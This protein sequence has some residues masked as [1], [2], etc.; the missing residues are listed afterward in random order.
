MIHN[1]PFFKINIFLIL[2]ILFSSLFEKQLIGNT[3][4]IVLTLL[5]FVLIAFLQWKNTPTVLTTAL[6][7]TSVFLIGFST[8]QF[9]KTNNILPKHKGVYL[10]ITKVLSE[11]EKVKRYLT[12]VISIADEGLQSTNAKA[13]LTFFGKE[14]LSPHSIVFVPT[15]LH[16]IS[17]NQFPF[18]YDY[19]DYLLN[20]D[21]HFK[22]STNTLEIIENVSY[23]FTF[24]DMI[25][26]R[27]EQIFP[28]A[29]YGISASLLIGDKS[30]LQKDEYQLFQQTGNMHLLALSGMHVGI[31][32]LILDLI[33]FWRKYLNIRTA[34]K[35]QLFYLPL[36][37]FYASVAGF[38][39]SILRAVSM[40]SILIIGKALYQKVNLLN[41]L[42]FISFCFLGYD[43]FLLFDIGF[44]LSFTAVLFISVFPYWKEVGKL[45]YW[46]KAILSIIIVSILAQL[47]T[48]SFTAYF[49]QYI[50]AYSLFSSIL[51]GFFTSFMM[52]T[53]LMILVLDA[54]QIPLD[55]LICSYEFLYFLFQ[56]W[57]YLFKELPQL[58]LVNIGAT[59]AFLLC[60]TIY[61]KLNNRKLIGLPIVLMLI[62]L[63]VQYITTYHQHQKTLYCYA[64]KT[65]A[66]SFIDQSH[67]YSFLLRDSVNAQFEYE[68]VIKKHQALF[69]YQE[70][71]FINMNQNK[72]VMEIQLNDGLI[73]QY[74]KPHF[75]LSKKDSTLLKINHLQ[76]KNQQTRIYP[77]Y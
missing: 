19:S 71:H 23:S 28:S 70:T 51:S 50:P 14:K 43:P 59:T 52:Y 64:T 44:I 32:V 39:P 73:F 27:I 65:P 38:T 58:P 41:L 77:L 16:S 56:K 2:G 60:I 10:E 62:T 74:L 49:F 8:F 31:I 67:I 1:A 20:K 22:V 63:T 66:F 3:Y 7:C 30:Y 46:K 11:K 13:L 17:K 55:W 40:F 53:G 68:T 34:R 57:L 36:L 21:I 15:S 5:F 29:L 42:C 12:K 37:W 25:Q 47:G 6:L 48:I 18:M 26:K 35:L 24:R 61:I 76:L 33:F 9:Q 45:P 54:L 75:I 4:L 69:P 72:E